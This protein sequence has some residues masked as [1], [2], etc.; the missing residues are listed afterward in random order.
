[1][2]EEALRARATN[3]LDSLSKHSKLFDNGTE[4]DIAIFKETGMFHEVL[5]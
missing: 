4:K 3:Q 5:Q 2:A 1:M